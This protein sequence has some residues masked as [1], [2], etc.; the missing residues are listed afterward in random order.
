MEQKTCR[1]ESYQGKK[2]IRES[3]GDTMMLWRRQ[4]RGMS[5]HTSEAEGNRELL[6]YAEASSDGLLRL[7]IEYKR[8]T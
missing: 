1:F 4:E 2:A 6:G 7:L 5:M 8:A 3:F